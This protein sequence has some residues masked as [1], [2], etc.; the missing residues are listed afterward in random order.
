MHATAI[1]IG[2]MSAL[3]LG[4]SLGALNGRRMCAPLIK[5]YE[6]RDAAQGELIKAQET[7]HD[8]L[9]K[10]IAALENKGNAFEE[11]ADA[12]RQRIAQLEGSL[13][14]RARL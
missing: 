8:A 3:V 1:A 2:A 7:L 5:S 11:L 14:L 9:M 6:T 12:Q 13:E 4:F 10:Q